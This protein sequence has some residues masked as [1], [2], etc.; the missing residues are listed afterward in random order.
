MTYRVYRATIAGGQNFSAPIKEVA[1]S[2]YTD[3]TAANNHRYYYVVRAADA[4]GN[5]DH[6]QV[7][8]SA[9]PNGPDWVFYEPF[10]PPAAAFFTDWTIV[11]GGTTSDSWTDTNPGNRSSAYL[12]DEFAV[13]DKQAAG[14]LGDF[15]E[16]LISPAI[17]LSNYTDIKFGFAHLYD[18]NWFETAE[19][20]YST[21]GAA[22]TVIESFAADEEG[23]EWYDLPELDEEPQVFFRFHYAAGSLGRY[24]AV[25]EIKV[26]GFAINTTTTTVTATTTTTTI[27]GDDDTADDDTADDD[28]AD[29]DDDFNPPDD[30]A[31]DDVAD[32]DTDDILDDDLDDD[33]AINDADSD[34]DD[35]EGSGS[36]CG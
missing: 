20:S 35:G 24:W 7:E 6:N 18:K 32:D 4:V 28:T 2:P 22:W 25:D 5:Q 36:C 14:L 16:Q 26:T 23:E 1:A 9:M 8:H 34:D 31:D 27:P 17:D 12:V 29:D 19:V 11:D 30:D 15:D 33:A 13:A 21:D 3:T 10:D